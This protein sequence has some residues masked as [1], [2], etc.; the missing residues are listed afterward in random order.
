MVNPRKIVVIGD[1]NV[2]SSIAFA[3][4][5][6]LAVAFIAVGTIWGTF[7]SHNI[8]LTQT[9]CVI[10]P[11][12]A[13][14]IS[15]EKAEFSIN[16]MKKLRVNAIVGTPQEAASKLVYDILSTCDG[17]IKISHILYKFESIV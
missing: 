13:K 7:T 1:G 11:M 10:I 8:G 2:G 15:E 17:L 6:I 3:L 16:T 12:G 9:G 4:V 5:M 14:D